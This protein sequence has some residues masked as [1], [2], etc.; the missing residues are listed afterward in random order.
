SILKE[1]SSALR[2]FRL[3]LSKNVALTIRK[4]MSLFGIE[5]PERM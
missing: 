3:V 2:D 5:V 1:E 4:G